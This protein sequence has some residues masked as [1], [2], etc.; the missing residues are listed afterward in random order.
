L[1]K[2]QKSKANFLLELIQNADDSTYTGL[3]PIMK[4][5]ITPT[6]IKITYE[7]DGFNAEDVK[8]ICGI[9]KSTRVRSDFRFSLGDE[10]LG[11][12]SVFK[13][14]SRA[15][16]QSG[17]YSFFFE[18]NAG[19]TGMGLIT[20]QF[21]EQQTPQ[22]RGTTIT[23]TLRKDVQ[24]ETI[25]KHFEDL[26]EDLLMFT[27]NLEG[28]HV[29][30]DSGVVSSRYIYKASPRTSINETGGS[31]IEKCYCTTTKKVT[32]LPHDSRRDRDE[33]EVL[34]AFPVSSDD[35]PLVKEQNL[36][37]FCS[38]GKFGFPVRSQTIVV[39]EGLSV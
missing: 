18:H 12:K 9:G 7:E 1:D 24:I 14:A 22:S 39:M 10:S 34:L 35:Q 26:P 32:N 37:T 28:L 8:A 25:L 23:L 20:P 29:M 5:S 2:L 4:F 15:H 21:C 16:I 38:L 33:V 36:Y 13:V 19:E 6:E 11:F 17:P 31:Y 30:S 27:R 3:S